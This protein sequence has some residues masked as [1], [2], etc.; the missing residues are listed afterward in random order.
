MEPIILESCHSTWIIDQD[1][2]R[3]RRVLKHIE[4]G[5]QSIAT[6]WRPY[7]QFHFD[8]QGKSFVVALNPD[9]THQIR[10]WRHTEDCVQCGEHATAELSLEDLS[11]A[12]SI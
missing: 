12:V 11:T 8:P 4:V 1:R 6:E 3:F 9:G 2:M 5:H 10:S 7:C